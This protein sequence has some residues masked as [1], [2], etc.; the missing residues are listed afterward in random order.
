MEIALS[1]IGSEQ[2]RIIVAEAVNF[3]QSY[4]VLTRVRPK[5]RIC[6]VS[7]SKQIWA[8]WMMQ[9]SLPQAQTM[10]LCLGV[11]ERIHAWLFIEQKQP[12]SNAWSMNRQ[13]SSEVN[14]LELCPDNLQWQ[15]SCHYFK[16]PACKSWLNSSIRKF[17]FAIC[18]QIFSEWQ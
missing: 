16:L 5:L 12:V 9:E 18:G 8:Y 2:K 3:S 17:A 6:D 7:S 4:R 10:R 1:W 11:V 14:S 15:L 13:L